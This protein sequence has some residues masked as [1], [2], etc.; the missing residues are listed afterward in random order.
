[1]VQIIDSHKVTYGKVAFFYLSKTYFNFIHTFSLKLKKQNMKN[2]KDKIIGI[3]S[4]IGVMAI[5][6]SS[7][8]QQNQNGKY[9]I[10]VGVDDDKGSIIL[11]MDTQT[12]ET[13]RWDKKGLRRFEGRWVKFIENRWE[14]PLA[15]INITRLI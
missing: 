11:K 14:S 1:M 12:G 10:A 15:L 9:M 2:W 13:Y 3:L 4:A 7:Y 5:L 6:M 8:S